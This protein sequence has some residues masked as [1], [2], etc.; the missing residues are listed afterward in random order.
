M[1]AQMYANSLFILVA[2]LYFK[3]F[4]LSCLIVNLFLN[5]S[6]NCN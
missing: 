1:K 2:S 4:Q 6:N 3:L 5:L